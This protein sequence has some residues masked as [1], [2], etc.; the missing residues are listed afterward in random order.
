[1]SDRID[2]QK[3]GLNSSALSLGKKALPIVS[4]SYVL[5]CSSIGIA[6]LF[7]QIGWL[8]W[9]LWVVASIGMQREVVQLTK[10][11]GTTHK[12]GHHFKNQVWLGGLIL[13]GLVLGRIY[14]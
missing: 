5:A 9:P 6:A 1:M 8:F 10:V 11:L 4:I 14:F 2:D 13:L 7:A 3:V 12:Y